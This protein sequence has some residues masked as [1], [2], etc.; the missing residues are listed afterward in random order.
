MLTC[1]HLGSRPKRSR[2]IANRKLKSMGERYLQ[3]R[4]GTTGR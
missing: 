2:S 4:A 3:W 1:F